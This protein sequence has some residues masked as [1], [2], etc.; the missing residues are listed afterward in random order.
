M[1]KAFTRQRRKSLAYLA[2]V[3]F[4]LQL[5]LTGLYAPAMAFAAP[6]AAPEDARTV[7]I[8]TGTGFKKVALDATGRPVTPASHRDKTAFCPICF[9]LAGGVVIT[10]HLTVVEPSHIDIPLFLS[11]IAF[12]WPANGPPSRPTSRGPPA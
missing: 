9:G 5:F 6:G 10:T 11:G 1:R 7:L 8:C 4:V 2:T 12:T 3:G